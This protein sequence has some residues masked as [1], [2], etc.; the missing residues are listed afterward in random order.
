[1]RTDPGPLNSITAP[2]ADHPNISAY[3]HRPIIWVTAKFFE[4]KRIVSGIL[5]E[6]SKGAS[7]RPFLRGIQ[8]LV[9]LPKAPSSPGK[10]HAIQIERLTTFSCRLLD[11][12]LQFGAR[13]RFVNDLLPA[14]VIHLRKLTQLV[15]DG[16]SLCLRKFRQLVDDLGCTH[17]PSIIR[18]RPFVSVVSLSRSPVVPQSMVRS[19]HVE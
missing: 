4:L 17:V 1:M 3:S 6:Q 10:S 15:E 14:I 11:E 5:Q 12:R 7:R 19:Q 9:R 16:L 18:S 2:F 8:S 13:H